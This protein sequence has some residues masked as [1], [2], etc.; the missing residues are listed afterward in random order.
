MALII[1]TSSHIYT[2]VIE[3]AYGI[4][5]ILLVTPTATRGKWQNSLITY[6]ISSYPR[7][8]DLSEE[9]VNREI[10]RAFEVWADVSSLTF[11]R[12]FDADDANIEIR[13]K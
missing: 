6:K 9:E 1:I 8:E 12:K 5:Q 13:Y 11:E 2:K 4:I 3:I 7:Y 10:A